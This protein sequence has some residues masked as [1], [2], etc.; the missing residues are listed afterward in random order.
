MMR[1]LL[2][3]L[4]AIPQWDAPK[5]KFEK[6]GTF[7]MSRVDNLGKIYLVRKHEI[8][9]YD[10]EGRQLNRNSDKLLGRIYDLDATNGLELLVYFQDQSQV[11]FYDN[12]LAAKGRAISLEQLGFEQVSEVCTSYGNGLWLFDRVKFELIRL[13]KQNNFTVRT[14]SLFPVLGFIP[15][16]VHMREADNRL[17]MSDPDRGILVF[18]I[19]GTY[20]NTLPI[21]GINFFQ[22]YK[23]GI[24]FAREKFLLR[25]D[26][27][28]LKTDTLSIHSEN[29]NEWLYRDKWFGVLNDKGFSVYDLP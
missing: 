5:L 15:N 17:Y 20:Y 4:F 29:V 7:D 19:F 25:F 23:K 2:I 16:V 28:E 12:Q 14:G 8:W 1:L 24:Y 22:V 11:V 13:D 6:S 21:K 18:D 3:L 10:L 9:Q 27:T 26:L